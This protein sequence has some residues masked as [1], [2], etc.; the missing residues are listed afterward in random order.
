MITH[1]SP[2]LTG[3]LDLTKQLAVPVI[4]QDRSGRMHSTRLATTYSLSCLSKTTSLGHEDDL[5]W[6]D[7]GQVQ[8]KT[9]S[10]YDL[11]KHTA[12]RSPRTKEGDFRTS[13]D[14]LLD[15]GRRHPYPASMSPQLLED[16]IRARASASPLLIK[17][18][19]PNPGVNISLMEGG[20]HSV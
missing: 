9:T 14:D 15:R 2:Q 5:P 13:E 10:K 4:P 8:L 1:R 19:I 18:D 6:S 17:D 12:L 3:L 7:P 20:R 16:D 11:L